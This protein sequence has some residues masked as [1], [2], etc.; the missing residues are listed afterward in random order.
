MNKINK[1]LAIQILH[2]LNAYKYAVNGYYN[3]WGENDRGA[4]EKED[5][6][7]IKDILNKINPQVKREI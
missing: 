4:Y 7:I 3:G 2:S 1:L 5:I 6:E